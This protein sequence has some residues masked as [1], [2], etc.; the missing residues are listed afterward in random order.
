[1][2]HE[3]KNDRLKAAL[4]DG[5][6]S[7]PSRNDNPEVEDTASRIVFDDQRNTVAEGACFEGRYVLR[8]ERV[9]CRGCFCSVGRAGNEK[10]GGKQK[11]CR[12]GKD[13]PAD[14]PPVVF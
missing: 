4:F 7:C 10:H 12:C 6:E 5:D 9:V 3:G 2:G 13:R 1:M 8:I 14:K 11:N